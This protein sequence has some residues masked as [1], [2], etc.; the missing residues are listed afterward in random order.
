M[1]KTL[2]FLCIA[3]FAATCHSPTPQGLSGPDEALIAK[4]R[5]IFFTETFNGNGRTC[6]TCHPEENNF[7]IDPA[8]IAALPSDDPLFVAE[9][10]PELKD[11]FENPRLMR[12]FGLI[13]ENADGY[14]DLANSFVLRSVPHTL[15]LRTSVSGDP[16]P[17]TGWSGDGA[18]GDGSLRA[19]AT[20]AVIQHFTRT[21]NRVPGVDFRLPTREELDALSAYQLSLGRQEELLLPL[22]LKSRSAEQGQELFNDSKTG[23]CS[24]CHFNAGANGNPALFGRNAGNLNFDTGVENIPSHPR[25]RTGESMP[26]DDGAGVP[27]DGTFNTPSL[28]EAADTGPY[29]HNN[30]IDSL[31]AA[32]AFYSSDTFNSSEAGRLIREET[33]SG[34]HL[35]PSESAAVASFLRVINALE[36]IRQS[37]IHLERYAAKNFQNF[38][39]G[40]ALLQ[41]AVSETQDCIR[42]LTEGGLHPEA[43]EYL[44]EAV[45][46]TLKAQSNLFF[47]RRLARR[48]IESQKKARD[49]LVEF[50]GS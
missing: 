31:E 5:E 15:G 50:T 6:G 8:F 9:N 49:E 43:V 17:M 10:N 41:R 34:I 26:P 4:G 30:S 3:T 18:P 48:A 36:N 14:H 44:Q 22:P 2:I 47:K 27:G 45:R 23:K 20:G 21:L 46:Q 32:V 24:F 19:F 35:D 42:V 40:T 39:R 12:Q 13:L 16:E 29:F 25:N 1:K 7:T 28:V 33:G 37:I 38:N 11:H